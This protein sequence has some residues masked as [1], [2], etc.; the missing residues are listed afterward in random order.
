[1]SLPTSKIQ[2]ASILTLQLMPM[3]HEPLIEPAARNGEAENA[4]IISQAIVRL[5]ID[6]MIQQTPKKISIR[7]TDLAIHPIQDQGMGRYLRG[8]KSSV[9]SSKPMLRTT[10]NMHQADEAD[11]VVQTSVN[12]HLHRTSFALSI[13]RAHCASTL[14]ITLVS[15]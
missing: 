12:K 6:S 13:L 11:N 9:W 3:T 2:L 4:M 14:L 1:M 5:R 15:T 10:K 8:P 7:L